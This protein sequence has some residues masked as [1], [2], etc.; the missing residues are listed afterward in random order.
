MR[1]L[2]EQL[3]EAIRRMDRMTARIEAIE[4]AIEKMNANEK[5]LNSKL[6]ECV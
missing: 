5:L 1:N 3:L 4:Q 2:R 6:G